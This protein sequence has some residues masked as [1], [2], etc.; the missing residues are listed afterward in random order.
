MFN[1]ALKVRLCLI[2]FMTE[3][4]DQNEKNLDQ[5]LSQELN[6][7][8][9]SKNINK[10][11]KLNWL[12]NLYLRESPL[13]KL[14]SLQLGWLQKDKF[15]SLL[16]SKDEEKIKHGFD[17]IR[18]YLYTCSEASPYLKELF[19]EKIG[20]DSKE[21]RQLFAEKNSRDIATAFI[22]K[23]KSDKP[24]D[25]QQ[26]SEAMKT[27]GEKLKVKGRSL[28]MPIRIGTTGSMQGLELPILFSILGYEQVCCR[29]EESL[30]SK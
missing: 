4:Q 26:F 12:N 24:Q 3:K 18:K 13:A 30:K 21:A 10:K 14:W 9:I 6:F 15:L 22:E 16:L 29:L 5:E 17:C 7:E 23:L 28:F 25:P 27:V 8:E 11:S 19:T 1:T 2:F 20:I